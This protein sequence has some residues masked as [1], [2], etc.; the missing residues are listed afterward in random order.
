VPVR[1]AIGTRTI[2][3]AASKRRNSFPDAGA[4]VDAHGRYRLAQAGENMDA[5]D[6]CVSDK[7]DSLV[8][9]RILWMT[10]L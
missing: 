7:H 4:T 8:F 5:A 1:E 2:H 10:Y 9:M 3:L 6:R